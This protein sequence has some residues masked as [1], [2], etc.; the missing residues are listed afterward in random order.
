MSHVA[1]Y[2]DASL[3]V[4]CTACKIAC[5]DE[6]Q[7][8]DNELYLKFRS[9]EDGTYPKA[10]YNI[11]R[12]SCNHCQEAPCVEACPSGCLSKDAKTG[13]TRVEVEKCTGCGYCET[14]CPYDS[15]WIENGHV[16]KCVG[17][18]DR[19]EAG[20]K[21]S[22]VEVCP[23][24]AL[25][26]GDREKMIKKGEARVAQIKDK[27]PNANLY[28]KD[29]LGGL[30]LI[31]VLTDKPEMFGLEGQPETPVTLGLWKSVLQPLSVLGVAG[32]AAGVAALY[33]F[34]RKAHVNETH[35]LHEDH[36]DS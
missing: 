20:M 19:V 1:I 6:Y 12:H 34:A 14:V 8:K 21:P 35:D 9:K 10:M 31:M 28:G 33:P 16:N 24:H 7:L 17:C 5:N 23:T 32:A 26:F 2:F 13:M 27:Y 4:E 3:C 11:C 22:C 18:L 25:E 29:Q 30:H 36:G 15:V